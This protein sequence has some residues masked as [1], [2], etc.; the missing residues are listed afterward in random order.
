LDWVPAAIVTM[1]SAQA[2]AQIYVDGSLQTNGDGT[3]WSTAF[4]SIH[5]AIGPAQTSGLPIWVKAGTYKPHGSD[6]NVSFTVTAPAVIYGGFDGTETD[7]EERDVAANPTYLDGD[8]GNNDQPDFGNRGDNSYHVVRIDVTTSWGANAQVVVDGFIIRGG[9]ADGGGSGPGAVAAG[10]GVLLE[11]AIILDS[12]RRLVLRETIVADCMAGNAGG[13]V[14]AKDTFIEIRDVR[15][16]GNLVTGD[17]GA[18]YGGG[19]LLSGPLR[20]TR[21]VIAGN[22]AVNSVGGGA[23]IGGYPDPELESRLVNVEII[24][25]RSG[26]SGGG[27]YI[28]GPFNALANCLLAKNHVEEDTSPVGGTPGVGGGAYIVGEARFINPT[29]VD[30]TAV[31]EQPFHTQ[32]GSGAGIGIK[33]SPFSG[34]DGFFAFKNGA[35]WGNEVTTTSG[36][37]DHHSAQLMTVPSGTLAQSLLVYSN[38]QNYAGCLSACGTDPDVWMN[39]GDDLSAHDPLFNDPSSND[40]RH[41]SGAMAAAGENLLV[42]DDENDLDDNGITNEALPLDLTL[43]PRFLG[44]AVDMGAHEW[45]VGDL[46]LDGALDGADLGALL[47]NWGN[48]GLGDLDGDGIV[49]GADLGI[50]LNNWGPCPSE[51]ES[52]ESMLLSGGGAFEALYGEYV[53]ELL[54][55]WGFET[56][57]EFLAWLETLEGWEVALI[58]EDL[59]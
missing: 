27:L 7:F 49:D 18:P 44:A 2:S 54:E 55:T 39:I 11:N 6:R 23:S 24:G 33:W 31:N 41:R 51:N 17:V 48:P 28:E 22:R 21:C 4:N 3:S 9:N 56:W 40:Y 52:G 58:L 46:E 20:A 59:L 42:P 16:D 35:A 12:E 30:N 50:L 19:G 45:C 36:P 57:G 5:P 43:G 26:A 25:N 34:S 13:G 37:V 1:V 29:V 14:S 47:N 10:G 8:L 38:V 15:V 53:D 32:V